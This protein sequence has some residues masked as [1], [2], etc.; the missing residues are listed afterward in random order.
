MGNQTASTDPIGLGLIVLLVIA[1]FVVLA[2]VSKLHYQHENEKLRTEREKG[3][4][5]P[6]SPE[7]KA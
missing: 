6:N 1:V 5:Q 7:K 4:E 3:R 2:Y